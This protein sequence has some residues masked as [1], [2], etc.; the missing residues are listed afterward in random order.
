MEKIKIIIADDMSD[1]RNYYEMIIK[2]END[3]QIIGTASS[4]EKAYELA[5]KLLPDIILMDIQMEAEY[6]GI[7][8]I[9]KIKEV[10]PDIKIIVLTIH[11]DDEM[12]FRAYAAGAV[13]F[14]TKNSSVADI[15]NSM[16][17]VH[18]DSLAL[19]PDIAKKL[20]N[21]FS[22]MR[23]EQG[24]MIYTLNT[25]SKLTTSEFDVI[26]AIYHG[27]TNGQIAK[28]RSVEVVTVR[29]QVNKI[30]KKFNMKNMNEVI[31]ALKKLKLFDIYE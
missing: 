29:T 12:L 6:A 16:R 24:S 27:N 11:E 25:I 19:R 14:I 5:I 20:M 31:E 21:E 18:N 30:L 7:D 2:R 13:D 3:M 17:S 15:L 9:K 10:C 8:A 4:G 28:Q 23:N 1:I 22:R 26:K